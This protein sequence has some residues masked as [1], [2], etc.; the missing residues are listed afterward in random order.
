MSDFSFVCLMET[1]FV[2]FLDTILLWVLNLHNHEGEAVK[3]WRFNSR[4]F[5]VAHLCK[6]LSCTIKRF[7][8]A[9]LNLS[10]VKFQISLSLSFLEPLVSICFSQ[11]R[12]CWREVTNRYLLETVESDNLLF[13]PLFQYST[14]F[15]LSSNDIWCRGFFGLE[16]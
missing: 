13:F 9:F 14:S 8:L 2:I 1:N 6:S 3:F 4:L 11:I 7:S 12:S 5:L 16:V 10:I 15:F